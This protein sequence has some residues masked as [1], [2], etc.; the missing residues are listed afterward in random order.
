MELWADLGRCDSTLHMAMG[1]ST[2]S[3]SPPSQTSLPER[4]IQP[5]WMIK[6]CFSNVNT[7]SQRWAIH[8]FTLKIDLLVYDIDYSTTCMHTCKSSYGS[9]TS[10]FYAFL[11]TCLIDVKFMWVHDI[12]VKILKSLVYI[13]GL[14]VFQNAAHAVK[15]LIWPWM[16]LYLNIDCPSVLWSQ[17]ASC[18]HSVNK[19][20]AKSF[21][22]YRRIN[23]VLIQ[24][25]L[26][27]PA[28]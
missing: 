9:L 20:M 21:P 3:T 5:W 14:S 15:G 25:Y 22:K 10:K 28:E 23:T 19:N 13:Y 12:G 4:V 8:E 26:D 27:P 2:D 7:T 1:V 16:E 18:R 24:P 17:L 11:R 6:S